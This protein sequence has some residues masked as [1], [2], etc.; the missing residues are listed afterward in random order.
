VIKDRFMRRRF[1]NPI[2]ALVLLAA[3]TPPHASAPQP[4]QAQRPP[5]PKETQVP[6]DLF[7]V[8]GG[9]EV[10]VWAASPML[11]NPTNIDIDKDGR[12]WVAEG[13]R[14]RRHHDRQPA[15]DRIVVLEDT[16]GDGKADS[17]HTFVQEPGLIAPLLA[18]L[19]P[20]KVAMMAGM[21][22][23]LLWGAIAVTGTID[24]W[25]YHQ[26]VVE[27]RDWLLQHGVGAEHIDA[28]YALTG[29][30]LYAHAPPGVPTHKGEPDVPWITGWRP[31]PYK[32]A[33]VAEPSYTVVRS[34]RRPMLWAASD[35]LYVLEHT[36]VT[37]DWGLP[38][39]MA[40]EPWNP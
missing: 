39:L 34:F 4:P 16:N 5:I 27:A 22:G 31:L 14:Y 6:L 37:D 29:W 20:T 21:A 24:Q 26:T 12:I 32:V 3:G 13:V 18:R 7:Q 36:A 1:F 11:H 40:R 9:F 10:T 33:N 15:G 17:T 23:V 30:W 35:T 25:R 38:S 19:R 8:E 2:A 28:G